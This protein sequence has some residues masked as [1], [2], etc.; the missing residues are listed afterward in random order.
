MFHELVNIKF[1]MYKNS[2]KMTFRANHA[3]IFCEDGNSEKIIWPFLCTKLYIQYFEAVAGILLKTQIAC[4]V[5]LYSWVNNSASLYR[6]WCYNLH[7]QAPN[8]NHSYYSS[9]LAS[10]SYSVTI[11]SISRASFLICR[12]TVFVT[13]WKWVR[14]RHALMSCWSVY[15]D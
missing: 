10:R 2:N 4:D 9:W 3:G 6:A 12:A 5:K 13:A 15:T 11:L 14:K 1:C 7:I 8:L